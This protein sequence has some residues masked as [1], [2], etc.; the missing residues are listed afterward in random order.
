PT[1]ARPSSVQ[2]D[3]A[4]YDTN[5]IC[6]NADYLVSFMADAGDEFFAGRTSIG[7]WFWETSSFRLDR[8]TPLAF[9]DEIWVASSY[10]RDAV[11]P[12]VDI[13]VFVAPLPV[14]RP[15]TPALS[16]SD[17]GLPDGYLFLYAFIFIS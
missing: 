4:V 9:L 12:A 5:L 13:P 11:A 17:L 16:R 2:V 6:L 1:S 3:L 8:H 7:F 10:V 14:D 15:A